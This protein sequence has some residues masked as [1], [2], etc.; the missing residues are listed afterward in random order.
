MDKE[1]I[2]QNL[3]NIKSKYSHEGVEILGLFGSYANENAHEN[4]DI[5]ILIETKP[6]FLQRYSG[7]R[8][9]ARL[10][11]IKEDLQKLFDKEVDLVDK[12]GLLQHHNRYILDR[13]IYV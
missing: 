11:D 9:F 5:D 8:A 7:F 4:S 12:V 2:L 6:A 3:R 1:M 10:D 13:A